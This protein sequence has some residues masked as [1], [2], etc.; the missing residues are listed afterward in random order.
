[1]EAGPCEDVWWYHMDLRQRQGDH[2]GRGDGVGGQVEVVSAVDAP[3]A[4]PD[5]IER[6]VVVDGPTHAF[7][8][9]RRRGPG[10]ARQDGAD[11]Q[12]PTGA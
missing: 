11:D 5:D 3:A 10:S 7:L 4:L 2:Q 8:D 1:M 12:C 6:L 9:E